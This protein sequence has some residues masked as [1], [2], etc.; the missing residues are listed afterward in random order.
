MF[1]ER[2][3]TALYV[4]IYFINISKEPWNYRLYQKLP[5]L[6]Y[7]GFLFPNNYPLYKNRYVESSYSCLI[8]LTRF[9]MNKK[10]MLKLISQNLH[11]DF[12]IRRNSL[13]IADSVTGSSAFLTSWFLVIDILLWDGHTLFM[14]TFF[15][16]KNLTEITC[17]YKSQWVLGGVR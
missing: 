6:L 7:F 5:V 9:L 13:E 16:M 17:G 2:F 10:H 1:L 12:E 15:L 14:L 3:Y 11:F 8:N 4:I